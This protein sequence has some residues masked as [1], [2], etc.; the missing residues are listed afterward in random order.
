M[1]S[2]QQRVATI[3]YSKK[4]YNVF[5]NT[6]GGAWRYMVTSYFDTPVINSLL[7]M[8]NVLSM[9][10]ARAAAS[11]IDYVDDI[12]ERLTR[13]GEVKMRPGQ[14]DLSKAIRDSL[15]DNTP[16]A[17]EAPTGTGKTI[18]YLVGAM[19]ASKHLESALTGQTLPVV[20]A[21]ATVGLQNQVISND[22][23]K[24]IAAGLL[25]PDDVIIAKGRHR[26]FCNLA[27]QRL[28]SDDP[29]ENQYDF[30]DAEANVDVDGL[31]EMREMSEAYNA[32]TWK[33][34]IDSYDKPKP[35]FWARVQASG[36]T[37]I[38]RKCDFFEEC[39]YFD[40][41]KK[42]V[43]AR[44]V[45]ANHDIVLADLLSQMADQ[46]PVFPFNQYLLVVDESHHLPNKAMEAGASQADILKT[47][48]ALTGMATVSKKFF[49]TGILTK[50]F[51]S[52]DIG[53]ESFQTISLERALV[54]AHSAMKRIQVDPLNFHRRFPLGAIPADL[55]E[56]CQAVF[57]EVDALRDILGKA[58]TSLKNATTVNS[59]PKQKPF[60]AEAL[61][62]SSVMM[63]VL[64]RLWKATRSF[65]SD[66]PAVRWIF[67]NELNATLCVS[68]MEGDEM[69]KDLMWENPR[70][71]VAMVSATLQ[72][73]T[74][75]T[76]F[77]ERA[78]LP[79]EARDYAMKSSFP[80]EKNH[81]Y[82]E[83]MKHSPR[84]VERAKFEE[85]LLHKLPQVINPDEG[86]L[87]ICTSR[88]LMQILVPMLRSNF[89]GKVKAQ[90]EKA[91]KQLVDEHRADLDAGIG[92]ILIGLAT[93][94]EGLDLPAHYCTHV[95]ITALPFSVPT[96]P[97]EEERAERLGAAYFKKHAMPD[98]FVKLVQMVGR[99]MRRETDWGM[100]T[101][102]DNRLY[103]KAFGWEMLRALPNFKK[104]RIKRAKA[105]TLV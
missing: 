30:F 72:D 69:L 62:E 99:L 80:Y 33:G 39:P 56:K 68:P 86:T 52:K 51:D 102:F 2:S 65:V 20:V 71:R 8:S 58:S 94:A 96:N 9:A 98:T 22:L 7:T 17:A 18:A 87:I 104:Q 50:F 92:S 12:Y 49:A 37:C 82:I 34:D 100:I 16:L 54:Q 21:T 5:S 79:P 101:I 27:A 75:F 60:V 74:G 105:A 19:A 40:D 95:I 31:D 10:A 23:P 29:E 93:V 90:D 32:R 24:M 66:K 91:L 67:C 84:Q 6:R 36:D 70:V 89:P 15:V 1:S 3:D 38:G 85:E 103:S 97:V 4:L 42:L 61:Y 73:L 26:Y 55:M 11:P 14:A 47:L 81:I 45:V 48:N 43:K 59:D 64:T 83:E 88:K 53:P 57:T 41:R 77:R 46:E 28:L 35:I 63:G 78:G 13:G 76:R 44:V 25:A